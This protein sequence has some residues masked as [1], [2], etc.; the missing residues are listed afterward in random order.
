MGAFIALHVL[1]SLVGIAAGFVVI[2]G[3]IVSKKL[4]AWTA[5]FLA[6]TVL[7]SVTGFLL[8]ADHFT[9]AHAFGILS[10]IAL[11]AALWARYS[12]KMAGPWRPTYILSVLFAQ[13][14]NFFVLIVQSFQKVPLL[15]DLAPTQSEGPFAVSQLGALLLFIFLTVVA[16]RRFRPETNAVAHT[17]ANA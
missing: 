2:Y 4:D 16:L 3:F 6:A 15:H 7:T 17:L 5:V 1:I 13:Y 11:A 14:L 8:P 9:P 12:K 10:M